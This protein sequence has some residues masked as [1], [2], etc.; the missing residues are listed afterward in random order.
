M[1]EE[2][3][4]AE[5]YR[6]AEASFLLEGLDSSGDLHY[7]A[8]KARVIAG[9]IDIDEAIRQTVEHFKALGRATAPELIAAK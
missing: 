4:M 2:E 7:Q 3:V 8:M 6:Q 1:T 5:H 9:E